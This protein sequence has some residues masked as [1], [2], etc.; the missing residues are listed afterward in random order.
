[1]NAEDSFV[2]TRLDERW[3]KHTFVREL[4]PLHLHPQKVHNH[5]SER[6]QTLLYMLLFVFIVVGFFFRG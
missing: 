1:M 4:E 3:K 2:A 5:S 6:P